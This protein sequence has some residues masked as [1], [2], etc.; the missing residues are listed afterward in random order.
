MPDSEKKTRIFQILLIPFGQHDE[1]APKRNMLC[2]GLNNYCTC[3]SDASEE[4]ETV[5]VEV[6]HGCKMWNHYRSHEGSCQ[7]GSNTS[8]PH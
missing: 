5:I 8:L 3:R 7:L 2:Y 4:T 1:K 6:K